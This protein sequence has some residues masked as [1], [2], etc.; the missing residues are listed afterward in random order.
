[1]HTTLH[2]EWSLQPLHDKR[3]WYSKL[4]ADDTVLRE[5]FLYDGSKPNSNV[6]FY[7]NH[8]PLSEVDRQPARVISLQVA[9]LL[10]ATVYELCKE[11]EH[12]QLSTELKAVYA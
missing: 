5:G 11:P 7:D 2:L 12:T 9:K 1:M 3:Y 10:G 6:P 4:S 8:V